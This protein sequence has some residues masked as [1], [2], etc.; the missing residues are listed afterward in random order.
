M[1]KYSIVLDT[2]VL[3]SALR[4]KR[5][6][7]FRLISL[8]EKDKFKIN[9]SVPLILEYESI[10][11]QKLNNFNIDKTDVDIILDY[12]CSIGNKYDFFYLWR[13]FLKDPKDDFILEL[14]FTSD[15]DFIITF[16]KKDFRGAE[17][18]GIKILSP[19]EFLK[20]LEKKK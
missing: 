18:F 16:N 11:T 4:S 8:V 13:P 12:L 3:I 14:A 9:I 17:K 2:N 10:I 6:A 20:L 7:S 19:Q 15:S 5:G 1:K